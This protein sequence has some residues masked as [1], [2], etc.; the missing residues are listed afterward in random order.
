M[1]PPCAGKPN[2]RD[3]QAALRRRVTDLV[4]PDLH[5]LQH[6]QGLIVEGFVRERIEVG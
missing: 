5:H 1:P 6:E 3:K 2:R 4:T